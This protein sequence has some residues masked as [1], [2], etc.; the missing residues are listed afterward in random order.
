MGTALSGTYF[1]KV[2]C[3]LGQNMATQLRIN[4]L[5]TITA[6]TRTIA[7]DAVMP[8]L[9]CNTDPQS[10]PRLTDPADS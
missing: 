5:N 4:K 10:L 3:S 7:K 9:Y 2:M 8:V 6:F 1:L